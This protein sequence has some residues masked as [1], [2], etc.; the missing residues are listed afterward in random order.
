MINSL[1]IVNQSV[2]GGGNKFEESAT[3]EKLNSFELL[4]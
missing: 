2:P 1:E 3:T 4:L